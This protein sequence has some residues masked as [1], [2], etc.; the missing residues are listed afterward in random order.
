MLT[1]F[2]VRQQLKI[3]QPVVL[4]VQVLVIDFQAAWNWAFERFPDAPVNGSMDVLSFLTGRK[5]D[6]KVR[7]NLGLDGPRFGV[8][9]PSVPVLDGEHRCDAGAKKRR[10]RLERGLF[11]QHLFR[12]LD[13]LGGKLFASRN[14]PHVAQVADFVQSFVA[15][16]CFP[17]FHGKPPVVMNHKFTPN[18]VG[19]QA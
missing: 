3:F 1:I 5:V 16:H 17:I 18:L 10:H 8:P 15:K 13:L 12:L 2:T 4:A 11:L 7:P 14:A 19:L 9:Y 6:V